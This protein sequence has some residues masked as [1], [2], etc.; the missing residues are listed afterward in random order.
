[1]DIFNPNGSDDIIDRKI[2]G[3][4]PTGI[5]DFNRVKYHWTTELYREM[6]ATYWLPEI[7]PVS[8]D[9]PKYRALS[10]RREK[11]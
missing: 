6:L 4:S 1:M 8:R 5:S 7:I 11:L 9:R 10:K 2:I 3:G